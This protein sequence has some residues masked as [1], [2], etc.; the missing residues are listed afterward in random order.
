MAQVE[1]RSPH[2]CLLQNGISNVPSSIVATRD[3]DWIF[4]HCY[5]AVAGSRVCPWSCRREKR[6]DY[7]RLRNGRREVMGSSTGS[8]FWVVQSVA[9]NLDMEV[10]DIGV[11]AYTTRMRRCEDTGS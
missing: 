1:Y 10:G 8:E 2:I 11:S 7:K 5:V 9:E 3:V 6:H 4:M